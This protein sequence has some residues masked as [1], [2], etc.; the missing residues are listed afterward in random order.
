MQI[1]LQG[2]HEWKLIFIFSWRRSTERKKEIRGKPIKV[3]RPDSFFFFGS[4][5]RG[6]PYTAGGNFQN[7]NDE[8]EEEA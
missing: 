1:T 3:F 5:E 7:N 8:K 2:N 6:G 4:H